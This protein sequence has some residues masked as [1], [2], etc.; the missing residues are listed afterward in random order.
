MASSKEYLRFILEQLSDLEEIS[1]RAMMGEY[2]IYYRG[3]IIGGIYD[4]RLLVKLV[5][6]ALSYMTEAVYEL[7]HDGAKEMLLVD[8]VDNKEFLT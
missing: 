8:D 1:Y 6:S 2:I 7:P 3:K 4:D 5:K